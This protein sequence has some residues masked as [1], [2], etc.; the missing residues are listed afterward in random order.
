MRETGVRSRI[1][2]SGKGTSGMKTMKTGRIM[3]VVMTALAAAA[4]IFM[5]PVGMSRG[6]V[7]AGDAITSTRNTAPPG[8]AC[9]TGSAIKSAEEKSAMAPTG[10]EMTAIRPVP[11]MDAEAPPE[12]RT[13]TFAMG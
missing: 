8:T 11:P 7:S 13:A 4:V 10:N 5:V 9:P 2:G 1:R 12:F 6:E 3:A